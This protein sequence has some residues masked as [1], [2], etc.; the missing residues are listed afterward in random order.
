MRI[1]EIE[2]GHIDDINKRVLKEGAA[3]PEKAVYLTCTN[4]KAREINEQKLKSLKSK[5]FESYAKVSAKFDLKN[6][7]NAECLELKE[8]AQIMFLNN[9]SEGRWVNGSM[10]VIKKIFDQY[11]TVM[12]MDGPEVD[13][14]RHKWKLLHYRYNKE[15]K[16]LEQITLGTFEQYPIKPAWAVT[17]H[18]AQGKTFDKVFI[19]LDRSFSP[20]QA[21]VALSRCRRFSHL[22]LK[23]PLKREQI[24]IDYRVVRFV[25]KFQWDQSEKELTLEEKIHFITKAVED[26]SKIQITYLKN[27]NLKSSRIVK[28]E[29][30]RERDFKGVKYIGLEGHCFKRNEKR[31]F[32]V[33]RVL[34][35]KVLN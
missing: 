35:I 30:V 5:L 29:Y 4:R 6:A 23:S 26:G 25:K 33:D 34:E 7:P 16:Q 11:I 9:D 12:R 15:I 24:K 31:S 14:T 21:Y 22:Y 1:K 32:R 8:G 20:G 17:I 18:K 13:V 2:E 19:D 3:I 27:N 28:P 10:G